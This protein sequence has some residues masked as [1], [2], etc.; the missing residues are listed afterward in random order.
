MPGMTAQIWLDYSGFR[1]TGAILRRDGVTGISRYLAP[2]IP[3]CDW[4]RIT[5]AEF[6]DKINAGE[7]VVLNFEWYAGRCLEGWYAGVADGKVAYAQARYLGYAQGATIYFSH[8]TGVR[9]DYQVS[10]YLRGA[11]SQM[12]GYY[13]VDVYSGVDTVN[14]MHNAGCAPHPWQTKAWSYG[15]VSPVASMLQDLRQWYNGN[16]DENVVLRLPVGGHLETLRGRPQPP[17]GRHLRR[18][19]PSGSMPRGNYFGSISGPA[20]SHGGAY[21][22]ERPLVM[23]I[24]QRLQT[25][26]YAPKSAG[27]AD[28]IYGPP[29]VSAVAAWQRAHHRTLFWGRIYQPSWNALF[30]Y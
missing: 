16:A 7:D 28:G 23:A 20:R 25:L 30:T 2:N 11:R 21:A 1:T 8:D 4:K 27:W 26:G 18:A 9:N 5:K 15:V 29:T 22:W 19:W 12:R 3:A 17:P 6:D 13:E 10:H 14:A 24:Q